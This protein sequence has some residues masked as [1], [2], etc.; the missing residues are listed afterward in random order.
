VGIREHIDTLIGRPVRDYDPKRGL[1]HPPGTIY[2]L[3]LSWDASERGEPLTDML[4][5]F[6]DTPGADQV[7]GMVL[8]MWENA[9]H[10]AEGA[11]RIVAALVAARP[12]LTKLR[13][14]FLGD[15]SYEECEISWIQQTDVSPL[16]DAY[17]Q[18]E[19]FRVRGGQG[20]VMGWPQ[21]QF[22]KALIIESGGL[23]AE[24]VRAV[25]GAQLPLL[26]H[27]ELWLGSDEYGRTAT[28]V[29]LEPI[30]DGRQFPNLEYLGLRDCDIADEVALALAEA[31]ILRQIKVLDLSLGNL[32]DEGANA[33]RKNPA[34]AAL[35]K[36]DIHHHYV[37]PAV[38]NE[39]TA[40]GIELDASKP[41][42]PDEYDGEVHR[43]IAVSE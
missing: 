11:D 8:G 32:S 27:L 1:E 16:L 14:I 39:L 30:L 28:M 13:S 26:E 17:P 37:S 43:Y 23:S 15:I 41:K 34:I 6:L 22:L 4:A 2:R 19:Y 24:V 36:L 9:T 42:E 29:D 31:P 20:L 38:V 25:G 7:P 40:L 10:S 3:S 35:R 18:L 12:R 21:H 5:Q 33:L